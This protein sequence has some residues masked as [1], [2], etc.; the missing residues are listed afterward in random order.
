[1]TTWFT[2]TTRARCCLQ[3]MVRCLVAKTLSTLRSDIILLPT[4]L[5]KEKLAWHIVLLTQWWQTILPSHY[6][7]R[8]SEGSMNHQDCGL[9][10]VSQE[11]VGAS[12][13]NAN[14]EEE[15]WQDPELGNNVMMT[16][17]PV[18]LSPGGEKEKTKELPHKANFMGENKECAVN[19]RRPQNDVASKGYTRLQA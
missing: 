14:Q 15:D 17:V 3:E 13:G 8:N 16:P 11:C 12:P 19:S 4:I 6:R 1:M 10:L 7:A 18:Q 2:R 9:E 5:L